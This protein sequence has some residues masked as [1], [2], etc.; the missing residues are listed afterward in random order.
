M[1]SVGRAR[2]FDGAKGSF[3]CLLC[4]LTK[5]IAADKD[6]EAARKEG[7]EAGYRLAVDDLVKAAGRRAAPAKVETRSDRGEDENGAYEAA[8]ST[9]KPMKPVANLLP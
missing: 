4:A 2:R 9:R 8:T 3:A 6:V 1:L 7:Q 5:A